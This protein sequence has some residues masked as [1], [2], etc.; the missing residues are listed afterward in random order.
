MN[1]ENNVPHQE[2]IVIDGFLKELGGENYVR[3]LAVALAHFCFRNGPVEDMHADGKLSQEDMKTLNTYMVDRL[4]LFFLLLGLADIDSLKLA[5]AF[6]AQCGTDWDDPDLDRMLKEHF[7]NP[8][9]ICVLNKL[10]EEGKAATE[11]SDREKTGASFLVDG[12]S[13]DH[14]PDENLRSCPLCGS[15]LLIRDARTNLSFCLM[16]NREINTNKALAKAAGVPIQLV[17]DM[18]FISRTRNVRGQQKERM[19]AVAETLGVSL[20]FL[21]DFNPFSS[22]VR[23][24]DCKTCAPWATWNCRKE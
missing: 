8:E 22:T 13:Y 24:D 11:G 9:R 14:V 5:L 6:H 12:L 1:S 3:V 18:Q 16:H 10:R 17:T 15:D 20:D 23:C 7:I 19:E 2:S 4:G 21:L